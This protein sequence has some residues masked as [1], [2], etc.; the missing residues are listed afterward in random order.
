[1]PNRATAVGKIG[2]TI[3]A[4]GWVDDAQAIAVTRDGATWE[5]VQAPAVTGS[6]GAFYRARDALVG[7][8][9][10]SIEGSTHV[11]EILVS[12]DGRTWVV[13]PP[14]EIVDWSST[15]L[16]V[17]DGLLVL[18]DRPGRLVLG[19]VVRAAGSS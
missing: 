14:N 4:G 5:A 1:M 6:V 15:C 18:G 19:S 3:V 13:A 17:R 7:P 9:E 8:A 10:W 11:T 12:V 2:D 16:P